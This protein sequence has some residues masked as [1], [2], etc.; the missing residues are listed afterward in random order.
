MFSPAGQP[1][2]HGGSRS[3]YTGRRSRTAPARERPCAKS[4]N[5]VISRRSPLT[6]TTPAAIPQNGV[7][8]PA[9][10]TSLRLPDAGSNTGNLRGP[11][12]RGGM[13]K[14]A[15]VTALRSDSRPLL[16]DVSPVGAGTPL[17]GF[18]EDVHICVATA[19][20]YDTCP[21]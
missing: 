21:S 13:T 19:S 14:R 17:V 12:D 5:A 10:S 18:A 6:S 3:T 11:P 9:R 4:G 15:D 20:H 1:T 16:H 8:A 2:L 7:L